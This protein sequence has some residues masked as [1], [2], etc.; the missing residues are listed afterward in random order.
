M[1][2]EM[3]LLSPSFL[4]SPVPSFFGAGPSIRRRGRRKINHHQQRR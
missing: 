3:L 2:V 4:L 1:C